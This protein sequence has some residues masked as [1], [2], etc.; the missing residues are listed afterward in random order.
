MR[1]LD[2]LEWRILAL[3]LSSTI[4]VSVMLCISHVS[5][6]LA[7]VILG[8]CWKPGCNCALSDN[9][10]NGQWRRDI[11]RQYV[12]RPDVVRPMPHRRLLIYERGHADCHS[13]T[14]S[15]L[16][17]SHFVS[18]FS[19]TTTLLLVREDADGDYVG[20]LHE[21]IRCVQ[22]PKVHASA[23]VSITCHT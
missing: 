9:D 20:G 5:C 22:S 10:S 13:V 17:R 14:S 19:Y 7:L 12:S 1:T 4:P 18:N 16:H 21:D 11:M 15:S 6:W 3:I 8:R 2:P 23:F